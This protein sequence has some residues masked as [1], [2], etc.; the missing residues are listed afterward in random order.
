MHHYLVEYDFIEFGHKCHTAWSGMC[1]SENAAIKES[2]DWFGFERDGIE[3][4]KT[5]VRKLD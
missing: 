3:V 4:I 5:T 1:A 2:T